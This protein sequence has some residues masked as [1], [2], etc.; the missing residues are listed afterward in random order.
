MAL[1]RSPARTA[2]CAIVTVTLDASSN[3]PIYDD[4]FKVLFSIGTILLLGIVGLLVF[5]LIRQVTSSF[6]CR[7]PPH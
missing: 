7:F 4:L 3:A 6:P 5:S 1:P 2:W